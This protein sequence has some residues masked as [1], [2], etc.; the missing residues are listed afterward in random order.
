MTDVFRDR[1]YLTDIKRSRISRMAYS[2]KYPD[3]L[4]GT[5]NSRNHLMETQ[6]LVFY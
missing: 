3:I 4:Q 6:N 5:G 1:Q 2:V